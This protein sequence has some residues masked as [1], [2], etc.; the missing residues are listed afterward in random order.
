MEHNGIR[1]PLA[2]FSQHTGLDYFCCVTPLKRGRLKD[3]A[4]GKGV[5]WEAAMACL[6]RTDWF[7]PTAPPVGKQNRKTG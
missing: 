5:D 3:Y 4:E 6:G 1:V 2:V 7:R